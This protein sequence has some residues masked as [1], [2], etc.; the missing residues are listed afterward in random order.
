MHVQTQRLQYLQETSCLVLAGLVIAKFPP[1]M[2]T[3]MQF[4]ELHELT[5]H[6]K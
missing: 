1:T 3:T 6:T 2:Y 4:A 5:L